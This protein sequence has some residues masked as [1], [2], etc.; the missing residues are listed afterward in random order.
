MKNILLLVIILS[1]TSCA[2]AQNFGTSKL[3]SNQPASNQSLIY[4]LPQTAIAITVEVTQTTIIKGPYAEYA[5]KY[6]KLS[7]VPLKDSQTFAVSNIKLHTQAEAD[8]SQYYSITFKTF[9]D[10]LQHLFAVSEN[11]VILDFANAWRQVATKNLSNGS[12]NDQ[13]Y[14]PNILEKTSKEK[15]DTLYKTVMNDTSFVRIPVFKKQIQAKS[16]EEIIQET[17]HQLI[18]TRKH[19]I[20][21]L[22]GE[23]D[24]HPD[25]PALRVMVEE[26]SKY[27]ETL[28]RLFT[29]TKI[30]E[31]Q[32]YTFMFVPQINVMSKELG[33]F[34]PEKGMQN[35]K[36]P[37][38]SAISIQLTKEQEPAKGIVP[39]RAK[40]TL[41]VRAP[42]MADVTITLDDK[43]LFSTRI[44]VYQFGPVMVMPLN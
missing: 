14:D 40:N 37:G 28:L 13:L 6:L 24:F 21:I 20:K 12:A 16:E 39:D 35:E 34:N 32:Y 10:R 8:P 11:G 17:A 4:A 9:P 31:K 23:Y 18:K 22:R 7:D 25:G 26:L 29:G 5:G 19:K 36:T 38:S 43:N 44:P 27:E 3:K 33:Y 30:V 42:I 41:Y 2:V 15:V 1:V